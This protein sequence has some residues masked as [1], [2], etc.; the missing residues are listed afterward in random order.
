[1]PGGGGDGGAAEQQIAYRQGQEVKS[2]YARGDGIDAEMGGLDPKYHEAFQA[3]YWDAHAKKVE[4]EQMK[5]MFEQMMQGQQAQANA[6]SA[7]LAQAAQ[8]QEEAR[9][10]GLR[11]KR[12]NMISGYFEAANSA[13]SYVT[14]KIAGERANAAL[15]GVDYN[16]SDELKGERISNYFSTLWSEGN[17]QE[18]EGSFGE[19]GAG[20][21]EQTMWRGE[22]TESGPAG[23]VGDQKA[24]GGI[25]AKAKKTILTEEDN[26]L[27]ASSILGAA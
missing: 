12:D 21:F 23:S 26:Q 17:Q 11:G 7:Q 6:Y 10:S 8:A 24:G 15:M 27:G 16:M 13:T 19:V 3:G 9:L 14:D 20:G 18:L 25:R 5:M 2:R 22:G 1:M 4:G